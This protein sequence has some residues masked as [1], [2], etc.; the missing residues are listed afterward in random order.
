ME[1]K[2]KQDQW[3]DEQLAED[4][5]CKHMVI[6]QHTPWF[7]KSPEEKHLKNL[8]ME[9]DLRLRMLEKFQD[10]GVR[11]IFCG[12]YHRNGGGFYGNMEEVITCAMGYTKAQSGL[13]VVRVYENTIK[14]DFYG[15][16]DIPETLCLSEAST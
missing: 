9:N 14:H 12:H 10:A 15:M 4:S 6:F 16:D 1:L 11:A 8:N 2:E 13:R 3:L 7:L 5:K